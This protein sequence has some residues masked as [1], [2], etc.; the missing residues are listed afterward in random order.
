M[1]NTFADTLCTLA[2]EDEK[3]YLLAGDMGFGVLDKFQAENPDRYINAGIAEQNMTAV[4]AGLALE[5]NIVF[6]Y[7]FANFVTLRCLE[8]IRNCVAYH[9]AN[10][11]IVSIGAGMPYGAH[12]IT[13]HATDD[14]SVMR[15]IPDIKIF[16]PSD[17]YEAVAVTKAAY[18]IDGP[19]YIRLGK[20]REPLIHKH[21][22]KNYTIGSA[23][24]IFDGEDCAIFST[25]AI[26]QEALKAAK[27]LNSAGIS[28]ALFTFPTIKPLDVEVVEEYA[29]KCKML[30]TVEENNII[31]GFGSAVAEVVADL[32]GERAFV[33]RFGINDEFT[34]IVGNHDYLKGCYKLKAKNIFETV[35]RKMSESIN[36]SGGGLYRIKSLFHTRNIE[37]DLPIRIERFP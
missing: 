37:V 28:T 35:S 2:A 4:A 19:C 13:H 3:I 1:R 11:K 20:G 24:K 10:V 18:K 23:I 21:E 30:V 12:G 5:G 9:K 17:A 25:G 7:S 26:S 34:C 36:V 16:S 14:L 33:K 32:R 15:A 22:I 31:G 29:R 27:D 6:T 8:Q